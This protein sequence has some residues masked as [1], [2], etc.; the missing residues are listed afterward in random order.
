MENLFYTISIILSIF[1]FQNSRTSHLHLTYLSSHSQPLSVI[2]TLWHF[3]TFIKSLKWLPS[4]T[5]RFTRVFNHCTSTSTFS[6]CDLHGNRTLSLIYKPSTTTLE[7]FWGSS[8]R[9]TFSTITCLANTS[10][11]E[12]NWLLYTLYSFHEWDINCQMDI[13]SLYIFISS[14]SH[15]KHLIKII[16]NILIHTLSMEIFFSKSRFFLLISIHTCLI[17][18]FPLILIW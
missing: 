9:F 15:T 2:N 14:S 11:L 13:L 7:T 4:S 16:K 18:N 17:V 12:L 5:T 10:L 3:N 1:Y 8:S 6:T